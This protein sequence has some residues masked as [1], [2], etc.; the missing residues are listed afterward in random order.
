[1]PEICISLFSLFF[2][3]FAIFEVEY[4][5][6][7]ETASFLNNIYWPFFFWWQNPLILTD[8]IDVWNSKALFLRFLCN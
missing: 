3:K 7:V 5:S 2:F 6:V 4:H 1:M 8:A